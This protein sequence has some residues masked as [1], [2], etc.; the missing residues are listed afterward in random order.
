MLCV[1]LTCGVQ[2]VGFKSNTQKS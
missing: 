1:A 2:A